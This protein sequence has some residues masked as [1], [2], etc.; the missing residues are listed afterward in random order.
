MLWWLL[1][2]VGTDYLLVEKQR[3][4]GGQLTTE[5]EKGFI[6]EGGSDCFVG[7]NP[8]CSNSPKNWG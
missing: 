6:L 8:G 7:L 5:K 1:E 2:K 3:R 4:L